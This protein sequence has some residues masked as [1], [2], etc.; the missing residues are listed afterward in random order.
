MT[1]DEVLSRLKAI[2]VLASGRP[3]RQISVAF[4]HYLSH[5]FAPRLVR[6]RVRSL[7]QI[8]VAFAVMPV[9]HNRICL[10]GRPLASTPMAFNRLRTSSVVMPKRE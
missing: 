5:H 4:S 9:R 2:G 7:L 1:T 6:I 8:Y 10:G 3:P